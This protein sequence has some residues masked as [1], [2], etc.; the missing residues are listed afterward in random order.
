MAPRPLTSQHDWYLGSVLAATFN[1][2]PDDSSA[3]LILNHEKGVGGWGANADADDVELITSVGLVGERQPPR[4]TRGKTLT[5]NLRL[6]EP[7]GASYADLLDD[8]A[9]YSAAFQDR[10]TLGLMLMTPWEGL[11][12]APEAVELWASYGYIREFDSD[13][14]QTW[15]PTTAPS[16]FR[17][18]PILAFRQADGRWL[19]WNESGTPGEPMVFSD[20]DD[21]VTVENTGTAE[22]D[23]VIT[24]AGVTDGDDI[25]IGRDATGIYPEQSLWFRNLP[26]GTLVVNFTTRSAKIGSTDV[27]DH[28]DETNSDWWDP[29]VPAIPSG[30]F[31]VWRGP[32]AGGALTCSFFSARW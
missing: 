14:A 10:S 9:A 25:H 26:A 28:L 19:N 15:G 21:A 22:T 7:G 12:D 29:G 8:L 6:Q 18:E 17:R 5:Y 30:T 23:P 4:T 2:P 27:T 1:P 13:D 20:G 31:N 16:P 11:G 24:V 32:G 3:Q